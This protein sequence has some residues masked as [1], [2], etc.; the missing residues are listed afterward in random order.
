MQSKPSGDQPASK[1]FGD[2]EGQKSFMAEEGTDPPSPELTLARRHDERESLLRGF[3]PP[4][5][6][7]GRKKKV[8]LEKGGYEHNRREGG[9]GECTS[10]ILNPRRHRAD[11]S[12]QEGRP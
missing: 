5:G 11:G 6:A 8:C 7:E 4:R 10:S 2:N 9:V 1:T 3:L 12:K